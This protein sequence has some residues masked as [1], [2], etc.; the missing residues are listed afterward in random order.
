LPGIQYQGIVPNCLTGG[1][2]QD[3][4]DLES[5]ERENER[6]LDSLSESTSLLK[7][8]GVHHGL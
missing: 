3:R 6:G 8:V 1:N 4:V 7:N 5:L 2:C